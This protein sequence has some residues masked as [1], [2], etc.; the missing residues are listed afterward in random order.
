MNKKFI[1]DHLGTWVSADFMHLELSCLSFSPNPIRKPYG[2]SLVAQMVQ[3]LPA[4]Q[5][6][7]VWSLGREDSLEKGVDTHSSILAWKIPWTEEPVGLQSMESQ[8]VGHDWAIDT[9]TIGNAKVFGLQGQLLLCIY[10]SS[11]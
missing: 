9:H 2:A 3:N 1:D 5:E 6:T 8:R 7:R 11:T 10:I 4:V